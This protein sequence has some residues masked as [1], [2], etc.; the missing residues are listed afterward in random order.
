VGT[1]ILS[2]KKYLTYLKMAG[3]FEKFIVIHLA[4]KFLISYGTQSIITVFRRAR[5]WTLY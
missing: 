4:K 5:S 2:R 1:L 3:V